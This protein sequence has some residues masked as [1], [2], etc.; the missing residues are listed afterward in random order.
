MSRLGKVPVPLPSGVK[1]TAEGGAVSVA[2]PKG[3]LKFPLHS[4]LKV[5]VAGALVKVHRSGDTRETRTFHGLTRAMIAN[6]V[7]GV[8]SG[9]ERK[10]EING[11][12]WGAKVEGKDVVLTIG[13]CNPVRIAI[14]QG[15]TVEAPQ[16]TNVVVK[17]IDK[18]MVGELA[19]RIRK[20]RPP[21]PYNAK[22]IK[23]AEET[24]KRKQG[25]SFGTT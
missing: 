18:Q 14:P 19:A 15:V 23:Y 20:V 6:M 25:K 13:F 11:V 10:L 3:T 9:Y 7:T 17:G 8:T 12:G 2:G 5:E 24:I 1:I 22:G 4:A 16:P 21:E